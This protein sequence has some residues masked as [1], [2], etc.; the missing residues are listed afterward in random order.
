MQPYF[1]NRQACRRID[2]FPGVVMH[3]TSGEAMTMSLVE[4]EPGAVIPLHDHPH[5]QV[6]RMISGQAEFVVG[7]ERRIV[8]PGEMWRIPGGVP[9]QV[10]ALEE[11]VVAWDVFHPIR[12]DY[13]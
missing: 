5:E 4:M 9:H 11:P 10:T 2:P 7:E 8:G 1:V 6:G 13:R 3:T 12:E